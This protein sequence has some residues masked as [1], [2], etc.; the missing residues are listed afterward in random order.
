MFDDCRFLLAALHLSFL[1]E[2]KNEHHI[3]SALNQLPKGLEG[4]YDAAVYRINNRENA[5]HV[6]VAIKTLKLLTCAKE[7]L[8][9]KALQHALT[10]RDD[11]T[12]IHDDDLESISMVM[13]LCL[14]LIA[15]DHQ[16][17]TIR[18]VHET[19]QQYFRNYFREDDA[20][21]LIAR[22]C[23]R[24]FSL[25]AFFQGFE[26]PERFHEHLEQY[27][28]SNYAAR[29]WMEHIR[30]GL[31]DQFCQTILTTFAFQGTRDSVFQIYQRGKLS[32][33]DPSLPRFFRRAPKLQLLHLAA[34]FDLP[35]VAREV[36]RPRG[37]IQKLY[38]HNNTKSSDYW[39]NRDKRS[40]VL[41]QKD[42]YFDSTPLGIAATHGS[43]AV[44]R[45]LLKKG[46]YIEAPGGLSEKTPLLYAAQM[47]HIEM[48]RLLLDKGANT[49][50][51]DKGYETAQTA[52]HY[53]ARNGNV[54]L[55]NLLITRGA[56]VD[57]PG[58]MYIVIHSATY[59]GLLVRF[60][61]PGMTPLHW[62]AYHGQIDM[63]RLLLD[64]GAKIG[65]AT[66]HGESTALYLAVEAKR[67]DVS[68]YLL[69]RGADIE[70]KSEVGLRASKTGRKTALGLAQMNMVLDE[71]GY[72]D[73]FTVLDTWARERR[74]KKPPRCPCCF[75]LI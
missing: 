60:V 19:T 17:G 40:Q 62:A 54:G 32:F 58:K 9:S 11:C 56:H 66:T 52:L 46:A 23:L 51:R 68:K 18:L 37:N 57:A 1:E 74:Y 50:A 31:E 6:E 41:E 10:V 29:Y 8:G 48:V 27:P 39:A 16:S 7:H 2:Q 22:I 75:Q 3:L 20:N 33:R 38:F 61:E 71:A 5:N 55:A 14:G 43:T 4:T 70:A 44:A 72:K 30:E 65:A 36:L 26:T 25:P 53:A 34:L 13:S 12:D 69:E 73:I 47:D 45:V 67:L 49:G 15:M 42:N 24:Y 63:V 59:H 64:E 21:S 28:L 35:I